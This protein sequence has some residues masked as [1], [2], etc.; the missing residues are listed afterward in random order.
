MAARST[1]DPGN[2][3][4]SD[5]GEDDEENDRRNRVTIHETDRSLY[6]ETDLAASFLSHQKTSSSSVVTTGKPE[7]DPMMGSVF[8]EFSESYNQANENWGEPASEE[9]TKVVSVAFKETLSETTFK[10]LL[11]KI[12]LPEN[13]KFTQAKLV[14]PIVFTSVS[15]SIRSTDIKLQE[16]QPNMSKLTG[17]F[18]KLLSQLPNILKT[19]GD[20][21]D[22]KLEAIQTILDGIKMSG[23]ATQNLVSI[24]KKFLLSGVSNEYKDL[25]KF[26]EDTDSHLF[27]EDLEDS[28]K[29][30]KGRH[31]SLQALKPKTNYPHASKRKF[32]EILKNDR[33]TKRPMAGHKGTPQYQ[34]NSP[35]TLG[36]L[37]KQ[38]SRKNQYKNQKHGRN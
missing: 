37:K 17:C 2:S 13:C 15:P 14:N 35:S 8:K 23:Y 34:Y 20:H 5:F 16:V 33:P 24:R 4:N 1:A 31:Y 36:E 3:D 38:S 18:I 27:G 28:L 12:V 9:V 25:A 6:N 19:N 7:D 26:A 29:K 30:A 11:T 32:E 10:N 21:K 22:E